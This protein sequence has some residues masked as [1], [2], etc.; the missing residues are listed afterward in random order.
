MQND[1]K[2]KFESFYRDRVDPWDY[3]TSEYE[4][5][6]YREQISLVAHLTTPKRILEIACSTGAH[7]KLI[8]DAFPGAKITA[9]DIS[10]VAIA[11]AWR[12]INLP[13]SVDFYEAD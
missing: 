11:R 12:N 10:S 4:I 8:H 9:I 2:E 6:K 5:R 7:T 1:L 3:W 13:G